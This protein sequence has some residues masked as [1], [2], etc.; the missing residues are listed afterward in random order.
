MRVAAPPGSVFLSNPKRGVLLGFGQCFSSTRFGLHT[1]CLNLAVPRP[2]VCPE[3][4]SDLPLGNR[5]LGTSTAA[6]C[7]SPRLP[8]SAF[9]F[10]C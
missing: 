9:V 6:S 5:V 7:V 8:T 3:Q 4:V 1:W 2:K 10:Y